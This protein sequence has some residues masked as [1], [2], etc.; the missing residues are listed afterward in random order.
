MNNLKTSTVRAR[1]S[2]DK[3]ISQGGERF[4][5]RLVPGAAENRQK[6]MA[7]RKISTKTELM[8]KLLYEEAN[9]LQQAY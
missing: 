4:E 9:R 8:E 6:I 3:L 1:K 2:R 7:I 5:V